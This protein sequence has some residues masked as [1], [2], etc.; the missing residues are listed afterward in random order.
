MC[1]LWFQFLFQRHVPL[2]GKMGTVSME[3]YGIPKGLPG[4]RENVL[5]EASL[6]PEIVHNA[7]FFFLLTTYLRA[8]RIPV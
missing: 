5:W 3:L 7:I 4:T 1:T 6:L 2:L 8:K